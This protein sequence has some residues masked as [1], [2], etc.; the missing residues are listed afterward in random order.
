MKCEG[1]VHRLRPEGGHCYMF[2]EKPTDC[3]CGEYDTLKPVVT[4][5]VVVLLRCQNCDWQGAEGDIERGFPDIPKL[6]ERVAPGERVPYGE[7][8]KCGALLHEA[9]TLAKFLATVAVPDTEEW[10]QLFRENGGAVGAVDASYLESD[11]GAVV[12]PHGN[13]ELKFLSEEL[14]DVV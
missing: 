10:V 1:C 12:S 5:A 8:P 2:K 14:G 3:Q 7:C 9:P 13:G 11:V 4:A 6:C